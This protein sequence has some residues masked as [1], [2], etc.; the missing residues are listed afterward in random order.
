MP[1]TRLNGHHACCERPGSQQCISTHQ[2]SSRQAQ[3][4]VGI[5]VVSSPAAIGAGGVDLGGL[6][7]EQPAQGINLL[8]AC[9]SRALSWRSVKHLFSLGLLS[10]EL[11]GLQQRRRLPAA[12]SI[13]LLNANWQHS[14]Q[15]LHCFS[16]AGI[17]P[18]CSATSCQPLHCFSEAGI[19]PCCSAT[20]CQPLHCFSEAGIPPCCSAT[21]QASPRSKREGVTG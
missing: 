18:C 12:G 3:S 13:H 8:N 7:L 9:R 20:S 10:G 15:P 1:A 16:E 5:D 17:P 6:C 21:K 19:P 14:C 11:V 2:T 4:L